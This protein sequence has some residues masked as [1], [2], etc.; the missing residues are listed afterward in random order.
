MKVDCFFG[1]KVC[2]SK[3]PTCYITAITDDFS[4]FNRTYAELRMERPPL[5]LSLAKRGE[6]QATTESAENTEKKEFGRVFA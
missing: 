4:F 3:L 5:A 6:A 1:L 2:L